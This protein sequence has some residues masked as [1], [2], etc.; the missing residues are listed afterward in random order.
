MALKGTNYM[1]KSHKPLLSRAQAREEIRRQGIT[2]KQ[3][4]E[5]R[6]LNSK[7]VFEVLSGRKKGYWGE[8]H[9][10]AVLLGIKDGVV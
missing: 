6:G 2:I 9:K 5:E 7:I 3:W 10:A 8:S 1:D 4:S